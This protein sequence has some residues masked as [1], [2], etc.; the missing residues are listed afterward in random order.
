MR[1]ICVRGLG[2]YGFIAPSSTRELVTK[3]MLSLS[4][5]S[6]QDKYSRFLVMSSGWRKLRCI[7]LR[8]VLGASAITTWTAALPVGLNLQPRQDDGHWVDTWTSMPQLVEQ[9]NMPPSS[10]VGHPLDSSQQRSQGQHVIDRRR[11]N[12]Q[13]RN[14]S[15]DTPHVHWCREGPS[16]DFQHLRRK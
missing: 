5:S 7:A 1:V 13:G 14:S 4:G 12:V 2:S 16:T 9:S 6:C 3:V 15:P 10:F 8:L 11:R